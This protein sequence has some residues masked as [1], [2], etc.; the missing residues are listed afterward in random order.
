MISDG[1]CHGFT[2]DPLSDSSA[3]SSCQ[4]NFVFDSCSNQH[5]TLYLPQL[6]LEQ[7]FGH[8]SKKAKALVLSS[9]I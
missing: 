7:L 6:Y 3:E 5:A 2:P 4:R 8:K 1:F 9:Y